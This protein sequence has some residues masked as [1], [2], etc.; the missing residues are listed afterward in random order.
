MSFA[1]GYR[2]A[3]GGAVQI[4]YTDQPGIAVPGVLAF[5]SD[6]NLADSV[7]IGETDG[8]AAGK[9]VKF[10][11]VTDAIASQMPS[12]GA[13]LPDGGE[14]IS[15]FAG[16]LIFDE[17]MQSDADGVPGWA[18]GRMGQFVRPTRAGGRIWVEVK[19][20]ITVGSST[21]NWVTT[22]GGTAPAYVAG[23]FC[24]AALGGGAAGVSVALTNCAWVTGTTGA[25]IAMIEFLV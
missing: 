4:T 3:V 23:D 10:T 9:G 2:G 13:Y 8:I 1:T 21:V 16:I 14:S 15:D 7:Y 18:N 5:A 19:E 22:A 11:A 24:P 12:L 20:A 17:A 25:G 6:I